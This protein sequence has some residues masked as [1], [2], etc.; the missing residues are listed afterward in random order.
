MNIKGFTKEDVHIIVEG[1]MLKI[2]VNKVTMAEDKKGKNQKTLY[3]RYEIPPNL[4]VFNI[5]AEVNDGILKIT[6]PSIEGKV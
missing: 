2:V 4:N 5:T 3:R 1:N 6:I